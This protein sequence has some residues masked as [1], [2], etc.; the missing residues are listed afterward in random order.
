M[1]DLFDEVFGNADSSAVEEFY[2][3]SRRK[4]RDELPVVEFVANPWRENYTVKMINGVE[5]RTYTIGALAEALGVSVPT[6]RLWARDGRIPDAPYRLASKMVVHGK[7]VAGRRLYTE[8]LIDIVVKI[9]EA[10]GL[11]GKRRIIWDD[12]ETVPQQIAREWQQASINANK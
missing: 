3:G 6:L 11:L 4:R 8:E 9:F 7:D 5:T 1:P 12:Y 2:P 10:H